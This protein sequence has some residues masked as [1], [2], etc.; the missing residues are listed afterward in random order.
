MYLSCILD[1]EGESDVRGCHN[2]VGENNW[3]F[4]TFVTTL[5]QVLIL[6]WRSTRSVH[7]LE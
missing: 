2:K 7:A 5:G 4:D 3:Q 1:K 6:D